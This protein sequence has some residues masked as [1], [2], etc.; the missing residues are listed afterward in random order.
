MYNLKKNLPIINEDQKIFH[1]ID[2]I[3]KSKIKILFVVDKRNKLLGSVASGD[4]RRSIGKKIDLN[5]KVKK[6]MFKK[7]KYFYKR[8]ND[9]SPLK[10]LICVPIVNKKKQIIDFEY[11]KILTK[12]KKNTVFLMAGGKG[13]RLLP[14]TKNT[15]KPLLKIKGTPIIEKIIIN[16]RNQGF[17]NFIISVNYLGHKIKK[18]LGKGDKLKVN[19]DYINEKKYLGT[20]G[21][22]SLIDLKKTT[23]PIIVANSDL[24]SEIDYYN[25]I[26]YHNKKKSDLTICGKNKIFQMPYGEILQ[27]FEKI[28]KIIEKPNTF[29]LVNAGIYVINKSIL[30]NITTNKKLM[31]NEF[32]TEKIKK[33]K[34]IICYPVYE[35][36]VDIGNKL[37]FNNQR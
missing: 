37:D 11:N 30:E 8:N 15:P 4:L 31:M 2:R 29:H 35:N 9:L 26:N 33:R 6:I 36:W 27:K 19:I 34:K 18:Y 25:L 5:Q 7:P 22:L 13:V 32:I 23:F 24:I 12:D 20:A 14:L 21:S 28:N 16:F 1:A 3:I 10:D 17:K